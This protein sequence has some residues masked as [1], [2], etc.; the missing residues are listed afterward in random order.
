MNVFRIILL[1]LMLLFFLTKIGYA[2]EPTV[3]THSISNSGNEHRLQQLAEKAQSAM[4]STS[5][6][7]AA[8][9]ETGLGFLGIRY[10]RGG[11]RPESGGFDCSGLVKK[12]PD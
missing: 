7:I 12:V 8:T 5:A 11:N 4:V 6:G 10:R 9:I 2:S 3:S 1:S